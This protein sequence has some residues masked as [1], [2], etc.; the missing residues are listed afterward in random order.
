M[1]VSVYVAN[2]DN[3]WFDF[4]AAEPGL[5]EVNFWQPGGMGFHAIGPGE[6]FA[7]RLKS[8]RDR[9]GGFGVLSSSSV[10]PLQL[11]W[12]TFGRAN[13][14]ASYD[15][16]RRL[17]SRYKAEPVDATT[18]IGCRI[19]V[20][21]VFLPEELWLPLPPSWSRNIMGGKRFPTDEPDGLRLWH[22]LQALASAPAI[23]SFGGFRE[24]QARYGEPT[25]IAPR[26]GQGAFRIA[27]TEAYR[28]QCAISEGKVLPALDAAH[29]RPFAE[30]G[31][32]SKA[33]GILFRKD[34]HSVFDAGYA[35]VDTDYRFVV[36]DKVRELFQNGNEYRRLH[37][38]QL[39]LPLGRTDWPDKD[40][41]R[42]HNE[43]RFLG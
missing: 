16:L 5:Q 25:L 21:P 36:S 2:T 30:G 24:E 22:Q 33:N 19:L 6:L 41:L 4:L 23:A 20:Q 13:G 9:I 39:A 29:I 31:S 34:I 42:W 7:F 3:D 43:E 15:A 28:R 26:L 14:V 11:A 1:V 18:Q 17:I 8:P 40:L 12:E 38:K 37:G 10:L 35:T 32:H 27:V